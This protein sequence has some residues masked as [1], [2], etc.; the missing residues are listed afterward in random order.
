MNSPTPTEPRTA[1]GR[2][3]REIEPLTLVAVLLRNRRT[4]VLVPL[5]FAVVS[6]VLT[7]LTPR[8]YESDFTFMPQQ[9]EAGNQVGSL[10][11]QFGVRLGGF[12]EAESPTFYA[13]LIHSRAVLQPLIER[14]YTFSTDTGEITGT[15]A[16]IYEIEA[17]GPRR[18][19]DESLIDIAQRIRAYP[20]EPTG[21]I[22][23][24][25]QTRWPEFSHQLALAIID[26]VNQ[27]N[28]EVR[29]SRAQSEREFAERRLDEAEGELVAAETDLQRFMQSNQ[30]GVE[31]SPQLR[32]QFDRLSRQVD[33]R[34]AL[35]TSMMQAFEQARL[36]EVRNTPV[37]TV[38]ESPQIPARP[39]SR[40]GLIRLIVAL[41]LGLTVAALL[42]GTR[43][44]VDAARSE[45][46]Y[47]LQA[48]KDLGRQALGDLSLRR[49]ARS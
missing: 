43:E 47:D 49:R 16:Q 41:L 39:S 7:M 25:V 14:Q 37:I 24:E 17:K 1:P 34:Q 20:D 13:D 33:H 3:T 31:S 10:A 27:F 40:G 48:V 21:V 11:A 28:L 46:P 29:Q 2:S 32:L 38:V 15:Y 6:V 4:L 18:L 45:R 44:Y 22:E 36:D 5:L 23:V 35:V 12:G 8:Q 30:R 9:S 42:I 19:A 26:A